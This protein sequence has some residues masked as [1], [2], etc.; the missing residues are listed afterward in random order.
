LYQSVPLERLRKVTEISV[1]VADIWA[2]VRLQVLT[3]ANMKRTVFCDIA[4]CRPTLQR[5]VSIRT[6][7]P[8]Y[9]GSTHL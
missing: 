9:G 3:A 5:Y 8:D 4:R 1:W 7:R 6:L 2:D